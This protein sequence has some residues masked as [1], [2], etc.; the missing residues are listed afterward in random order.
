MMA[1]AKRIYTMLT[2]LVHVRLRKFHRD[3]PLQADR[4]QMVL[5]RSAE[6]SVDHRVYA[7]QA[8]GKE[9]SSI[10]VLITIAKP[11]SVTARA[12]HFHGVQETEHALSFINESRSFHV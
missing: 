11:S 5:M 10:C 1:S 7:N 8:L 2:E 4:R 12:A 3:H 6:R 9:M